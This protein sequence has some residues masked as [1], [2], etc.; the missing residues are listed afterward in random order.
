MTGI[1]G[2][3]GRRPRNI[4]D[5]KR[6]SKL[7]PT[8]IIVLEEILKDEKQLMMPDAKLRAAIEVVRQVIGMPR[9]QQEITGIMAMGTI[10]EIL[11]QQQIER[12]NRAQIVLLGEGLGGIDD[13]EGIPESEADSDSVCEGTPL[14]TQSNQNQAMGGIDG[15]NGQGASEGASEV[16]EAETA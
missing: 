3:S 5:R 14:A 9:Q 15:N 10:G 12:A 6:L 4:E 2:K 1:K 8:A 16:E 13:K 11:A 7:Y